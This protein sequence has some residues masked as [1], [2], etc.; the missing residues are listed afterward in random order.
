MACQGSATTRVS[1]SEQGACCSLGQ[2]FTKYRSWAK[3]SLP[4]VL[5]NDCDTGKRGTRGWLCPTSPVNPWDMP[6]PNESPWLFTGKNSRPCHNYVK[7]Y[8]FRDAHS[9]DS[10]GRL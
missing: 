4:P 1:L 10:V 3:F 5:V 2:G 7:V 9:T 8:L 6:P